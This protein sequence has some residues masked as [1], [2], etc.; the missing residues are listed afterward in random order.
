MPI[1]LLSL[2]VPNLPVHKLFL[3]VGRGSGSLE[4]RIFNLSSNEFDSV[5][6]YDAHDH[7]V[8]ILSVDENS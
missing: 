4:I 1:T 6:L 7:V 2:N 3:A 5:R 8:S